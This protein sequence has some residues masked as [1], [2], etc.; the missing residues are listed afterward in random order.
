MKEQHVTMKFGVKGLENIDEKELK[1]WIATFIVEDFK[2][3]T[4]VRR[5]RDKIA[6]HE[7]VD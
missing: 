6:P 4:L 3:R 1:Q 7:A 2:K 5:N